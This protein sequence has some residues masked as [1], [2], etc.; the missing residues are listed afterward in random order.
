MKT[1][2]GINNLAFSHETK[3]ILRKLCQSPHLN[4]STIDFKT[5]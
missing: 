1:V 4:P 2:E 3:T 5:I